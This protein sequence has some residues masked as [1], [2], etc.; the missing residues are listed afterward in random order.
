MKKSRTG[1]KGK[2]YLEPEE[3]MQDL[4]AAIQAKAIIPK[5]ANSEKRPEQVGALVGADKDRSG[6]PTLLH[7][8]FGEGDFDFIYLDILR[9]DLRLSQ[10]S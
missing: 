4:E 6:G 5:A 7:H 10:F 3:S 9:S 1:K 2:R 8:N